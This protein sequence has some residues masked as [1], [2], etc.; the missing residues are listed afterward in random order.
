MEEAFPSANDLE[1]WEGYFKDRVLELRAIQGT[2][3]GFAAATILLEVLAKLERGTGTGEL[4]KARY[5]QFVITW[6]PQYEAFQ[7]T[8]KFITTTVW[9]KS[10]TRAKTKKKLKSLPVQM[11]AIL[12]CGLVHSYS[13]VTNKEQRRTGGRNR[14]IWLTNREEAL[15]NN[16]KHLDNF[17]R[18]TPLPAIKDAAIFVAEEFLDDLDKV[19]EDLFAKARSSPRLAAR[20]EQ[21]LREQRPIGL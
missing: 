2:P 7:Y 9:N 18:T 5:I 4:G 8:Q 3:W 17:S 20:I 11:Y 19:I 6:M 14:S 16:W 15:A 13:F 1:Y 12:R 10:K 21:H